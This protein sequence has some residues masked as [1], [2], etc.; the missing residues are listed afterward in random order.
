MRHGDRRDEDMLVKNTVMK[1]GMGSNEEKEERE[2]EERISKKQRQ[3]GRRV[4]STRQMGVHF[5]AFITSRVKPTCAH[6]REDCDRIRGEEE[7]QQTFKDTFH[8]EFMFSF[9]D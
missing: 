3:E 5:V 8:F 9:R 7:Q 6:T 4:D 1:G 2:V